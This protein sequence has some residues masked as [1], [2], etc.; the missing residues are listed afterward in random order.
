MNQCQYTIVCS[1]T[2]TILHD[3]IITIEQLDD[4]II[5]ERKRGSFM[6]LFLA[7]YLLYRLSTVQ[8][9]LYNRIAS[10]TT[11]PKVPKSL[12]SFSF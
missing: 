5:V 12:C 8:H 10:I 9:H 3:V 2:I 4:V 7:I 11:S 6:D 1:E